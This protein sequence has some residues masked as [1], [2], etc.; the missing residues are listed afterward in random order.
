MRTDEGHGGR[1][2]VAG[3][4]E[5]EA[6]GPCQGVDDGQRGEKEVGRSDGGSENILGGH[7]L[8]AGVRFE[9]WISENMVLSSVGEAVKEEV[10][11]QEKQTPGAARRRA[12]GPFRGGR[13][14][15]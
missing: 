12:F 6:E 11:S 5:V 14:M 1:E 7:H 10:N 4:G 9:D 8:R 2:F 15:M 3:V 13:W